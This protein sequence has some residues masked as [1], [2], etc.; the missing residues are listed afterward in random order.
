MTLKIGTFIRIISDTF[1][2]QIPPSESTGRTSNQLKYQTV[3]SWFITYGAEET[4]RINEA[5]MK[6]KDNYANKIMNPNLEDDMPI[7]DATYLKSRISSELF[8]EIYDETELDELAI[9]ALIKKFKDEGI[10]VNK[11]NIVEDLTRI[12]FELLDARS[13]VDRKESIR[14]AEFLTDNKVK[15]GSKTINL[16]SELAVPDEPLKNE[17]KYI[18]ALLEVYEQDSGVEVKCIDDL[19]KL[20]VYYS[21]H[22][23][24]QRSYY[25]SALSVLHQIRDVFSDS[26]K[27]FEALKKETLEGI[28]DTLLEPQKN[29]L[30]RLNKSLQVV[31]FL[32]YGKS[33]LGR[34]ANGIIGSSEK[35]GIIHMLV[36]DGKVEWLVDYDTGI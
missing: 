1:A 33:Y 29:G 13:L 26:I 22:F 31:T 23:K 7:S 34:E 19:S 6:G 30:D 18:E 21:K 36:N 3:I 20:R 15:I 2:S 10:K 9:D 25:Y 11:R 4:E 5:M 14:Y 12:L 16:P 27:E 8:K 17:E 35:K 28:Q 24:V 32:P